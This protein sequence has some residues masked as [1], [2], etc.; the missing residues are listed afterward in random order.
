VRLHPNARMPRY[1][2]EAAY[3]Y[4]MIEGRPTDGMPFDDRVKQAFSNFAK[5][6]ELY[7]NVDVTVAREA[8]QS[9]R[10]TYFYDYYLMRQLPEY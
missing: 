10:Q 2:Q 7:D 9:Y 1:Y 6:A 8:L 3:L 4:C 5:I